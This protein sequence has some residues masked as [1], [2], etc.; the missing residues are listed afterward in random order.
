MLKLKKIA[1]T[2]GVASGKSTVCHFFR[3]LGAYVINADALVH[4]LLKSD[5]NLGQQIIRFL[6]E[7]IIQEGNL[8][9]KIIAEKVFNDPKKLETLEKILHPA[10]LRKIEERYIAISNG[11]NYTAFVVEIPLLFEIGSEN[12]YDA[13]VVVLADEAIAKKRFEQAG[14]LS[15]EYDRRMRRQMK[16]N[17]KAARADY[18]LHNNGSLDDLRR[19]TAEL[20]QKIITLSQ[21][22]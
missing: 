5:T 15:E 7:D 16:P 13:T 21:E 8:S 10:V 14:F 6:G 12:F 17:Q 19:Q 20:H 11:K 4:E 1:I 3:E 2:G 9:R 22:P 18:V